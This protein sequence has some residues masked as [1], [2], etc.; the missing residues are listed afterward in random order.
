MSHLR[1]LLVPI[2]ALITAV[3]AALV[4]LVTLS[5]PADAAGVVTVDVRGLPGNSTP[6]L[7]DTLQVTYT[8]PTNAIYTI[9]SVITVQLNGLSS[10]DV[11]VRGFGGGGLSSQDAGSGTVIFTDQT[12]VPLL[13]RHSQ[14]VNYLLTFGAGAPSGDVTVTV[15]A[16][17]NGNELGS[18]SAT[19][20]LG[21]PRFGKTTPPNTNPG[22]V[23]TFAAGPTYSLAPLPA[24]DQAAPISGAT[25]PKPLYFLGGL[26]VALGVLTLF[27]IF[28]PGG[29]PRAAGLALAD[30]R[31]AVSWQPQPGRA[32]GSPQW[33]AVT[34]PMER[35][36]Y[37][38]G[39][40]TARPVRDPGP[41]ENPPPWRQ[42]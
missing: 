15:S 39:H 21:G 13:G 19:T 26:L 22:Y 30:P 38:G 32:G 31:T 6:M 23:P 40:G 14:R 8:N 18:G 42:P 7:P 27:L 2:S 11:Q 1:R 20:T 5:A 16:D 34:R 24:G 29:R 17:D 12:P 36:S 33:P 4:T 9:N 10:S 37:D 35:R 28:R 3:I 25:V 41:G